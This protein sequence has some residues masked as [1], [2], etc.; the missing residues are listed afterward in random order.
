MFVEEYIYVF[1]EKNQAYA[2]VSRP[3]VC[4]ALQK[5]LQEKE[6]FWHQT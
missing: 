1:I 4:G 3:M 6:D 2:A 5:G